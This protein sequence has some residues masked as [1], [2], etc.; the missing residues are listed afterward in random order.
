MKAKLKSGAA[1][2][3][4]GIEKRNA[5]IMEAHRA[6]ESLRAIA[7]EV[8]MSWSGVRKIINQDKGAKA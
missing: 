6:G 7:H 4:K 1:A 5:A 2:A 8:G 3:D